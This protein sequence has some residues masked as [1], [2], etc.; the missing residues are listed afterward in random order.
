[1]DLS[2]SSTPGGLGAHSG[3]FR[4]WGKAR[5]TGS[6]ARFHLLSYHSLDVAAAGVHLLLARPHL[7]RDVAEFLAVE[8]GQLREWIAFLLAVHDVGKFADGFQG[9]R[10]D[11]VEELQGRKVHVP[12]DERHDTLGHRWALGTSV[13][14]GALVHLLAAQAPAMPPE[15]AHDLLE[16][17][18]AA[19][20]GHHGVP[21]RVTQPGLSWA[22]QFPPVVSD[23]ARA[24][25]SEAQELLLP[26][27]PPSVLVD[28]ERL[29]GFRRISWLVAGLAVAADWIGSNTAWFEYREQ[30]LA[31]DRYWVG[32]ALPCAERA[33]RESG[34]ATARPA[35]HVGV[36][37]LFPRLPGLTPLQGLADTLPLSDF[38]QLVIVEE[39]TGA[40]KTEAAVALAQRLIASG[41]AD[42]FYFALPTQATANAMHDRLST[43]H[44]QLFHDGALPTWVLAH[45]SSHMAHPL[46]TRNRDE[47]LHSYP[48][49]T[50][51]RQCTAWLADS[52][53]KALLAD[54]GVGT[55]DQA[56]LAVL[57]ARH[58]SMRLLGLARKVLIV[59]E[60]HA[61]DAYVHRLLTALLRFHAALGG[62]AVLLSATLPSRMRRDLV[63]AFAAGLGL[64]P[65]TPAADSYPL[66]THLSLDGLRELAFDSWGRAARRVVAR[67]LASGGDVVSLLSAVIR[68][69]GCAC[70]IRNSVDDAVE[71]FREW[72][73]RLGPERVSLFHGRFAL[74]DRLDVER[75]VLRRFGPDSGPAQRTGQLLI[76]TQ[77]VEQSLDLDF[78]GMVTD[79]APIDLLI[80]RAGRLG[81]HP[82]DEFGARI[83]GLDRRAAPLLGIAMPD[84]APDADS[85]W[86]SRAFPRGAWV[87][88]NHGQLWLTARWVAERGGFSMPGDAR[89]AIEFVYSEAAQDRVPDGLR[90]R[91]ARAEGRDR[92]DSALARLNSLDL[93]AGYSPSASMWQDD[94]WAPTRLGEPTTTIRLARRRADGF[95]PWAVGAARH[96]WQL[97]QLTVRQSRIAAEDPSGPVAQ[98]DALRATMPDGGEHCVV[99]PLEPDAEGWTGNAMDSRGI[100][101]R[102]RYDARN[103][104]RYGGAEVD[105][106]R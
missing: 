94:A 15:E 86:F 21:P 10:P 82:R 80:Q 87:Y 26:F 41:A 77:V 40:G 71:S 38:P 5:P 96:A 36:R 32:H 35:T 57:R 105:E 89:E 50:A 53:K 74:G 22:R 78:D 66:L 88:E 84:P 91:T 6:G 76:A 33:V 52:R 8:L 24:F 58:Q 34:L 17:W 99:I 30:P 90:G 81:R 103:G 43:V 51:S 3:H 25:V 1:M 61:C 79:L 7:A 83:S 31:L 44:R 11:I 97:S 42:G 19:V 60:V 16:T 54:A 45:S 12:Y 73:A 55:V 106:P 104:L 18:L 75:E 100:R 9:L 23:D 59:D 4:Y 64:E 95:V 47:G 67:P 63:D 49:A 29:R 98:I 93:D 14:P 13:R 101:V 20:T 92:A 37:R 72:A 62:S 39:V 2:S 102:V 69:G 70:W 85:H 27:G 65:P 28:Y 48:E 56:L 46:E 68:A